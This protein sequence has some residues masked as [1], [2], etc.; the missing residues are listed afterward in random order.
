MDVVD[1]DAQTIQHAGLHELLNKLVTGKVC[2]MAS[3]VI[4][5]TWAVATWYILWQVLWNTT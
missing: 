5:G 4:V 3:T 1:G 2:S